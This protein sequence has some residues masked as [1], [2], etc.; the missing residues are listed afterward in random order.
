MLCWALENQAG[1]SGTGS[2]PTMAFVVLW[3]QDKTSKHQARGSVQKNNNGNDINNSSWF[4]PDWDWH[5]IQWNAQFWSALFSLFWRIPIKRRCLD[6]PESSRMLLPGQISLP[7]PKQP[8][9]WSTSSQVS[10]PY[11]RVSCKWDH[12]KYTFSV[13]LDFFPSANH[14]EDASMS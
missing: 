10:F 6:N 8:L 1:V 5:F 4:L 14:F 11:P 9:S 3:V 12:A 7:I 13:C 2:C